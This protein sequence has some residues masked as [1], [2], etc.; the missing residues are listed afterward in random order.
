[1]SLWTK[2][3]R[4]PFGTSGELGAMVLLGSLGGKIPG[5]LLGEGSI[6]K[7][8]GD[9]DITNPERRKRSIKYLPKLIRT[10]NN[11]V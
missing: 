9:E 3:V 6:G 2:G 7:V 10:V 4:L 11:L 8:A 5:A 1:M